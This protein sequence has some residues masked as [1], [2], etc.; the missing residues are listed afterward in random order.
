MHVFILEIVLMVFTQKTHCN[1]APL[2]SLVESR[3][4]AFENPHTRNIDA[5]GV[6]IYPELY[7]MCNTT[8]FS[9]SWLHTEGSVAVTSVMCYPYDIIC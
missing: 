8:N 9:N 6:G 7:V 4:T 3:S 5:P 2:E 1:A